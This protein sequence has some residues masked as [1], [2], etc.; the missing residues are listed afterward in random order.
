MTTKIYGP[1]IE[2]N[3]GECPVPPETIVKGKLRCGGSEL[4]G[5][6]KEYYWRHGGGG[7][8]IVEYRTVIEQAVMNNFPHQNLHQLLVQ[9]RDKAEAW[10]GGEKPEGFCPELGICENLPSEPRKYNLLRDLM[11]T[12]P[13]G[14]GSRFYPVPHHDKGPEG[15]Y[16]HSSAQEMWNPEHEYARNRWALLEWL[17]EQTAHTITPRE[18]MTQQEIFEAAEKLLLAHSYTVIPPAKPLKFEDDLRHQPPLMTATEINALPHKAREYIHQLE[19]NTD[20]SGMVRENMQLL[21]TNK[22]LQIMYRNRTDELDR[23]KQALEL[24]RNGLATYRVVVTYM[25]ERA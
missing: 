9:L 8:D 16:T 17:I 22:G 21:D 20:P 25:L 3:G 13:A 24:A 10:L 5:L 14:T 12:W 4:S 19:A 6:A 7:A 18:S 23:V 15:G 2:W 11:A 1:W